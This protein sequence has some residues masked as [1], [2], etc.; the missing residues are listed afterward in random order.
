MVEV[1]GVRFNRNLRIYYFDPQHKQYKKNDRVIVET[2]NGLD[3]VTIAVAN[4]TVAEEDVVLPLKPVARALTPEDLK[5]LEQNE[6]NAKRA[7]QIF[8]KTLTELE[9]QLDLQLVNVRYNFDATHVVF[10]YTADE[11]VDF[12]VLVRKLATQLHVRI[13]MHQINLREKARIIGG[14]GPCGYDMCCASFLH[15]LHGSTIKMIKNQKLSLIPERI[16]GL[17]GK[18]LCCIRYE[19]DIYTELAALLPDVNQI[20]D[21]P[22]GKGKVVYVNVINQKIDV[23]FI[24]KN[25]APTRRQYEYAAL[26]E[27]LQESV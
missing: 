19:N 10:N 3:V 24:G 26:K 15:D 16:S 18:L 27:Q 6:K 1:V 22:D 2:V 14:I 11:R 12:R 8:R 4:K 23:Q 17:C 9:E 13:E 7:E 21:T 20:I 5:Q 25:G